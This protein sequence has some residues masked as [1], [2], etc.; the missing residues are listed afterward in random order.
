[1]GGMLSIFVG[2]D[3]SGNL[4]YPINLITGRMFKHQTD[5]ISGQG[6]KLSHSINKFE[7]LY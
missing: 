5:S 7:K 1:M 6:R 2:G 3:D 4:Q